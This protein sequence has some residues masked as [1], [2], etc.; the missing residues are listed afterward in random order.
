MNR[1]L[2][3]LL[4]VMTATS[5]GTD[6]TASHAEKRDE[7][8]YPSHG[9]APS[10][11]PPRKNG[12]GTRVVTLG[13]GT[14]VLDPTRAG[15]ATAVG[16]RAYLVDFGRG[17]VDRAEAAFR[18]GFGSLDVR[19]IHH[20]FATHLHSD[21]TV[22]LADLMMTPIA[23]GR[24]APLQIFGPPG[25]A[26]MVE[27]INGAYSEDLRVRAEGRPIGTLPGYQ[28]V[29]REIKEG[30]V[31]RDE[32]VTVKAIRVTHGT[33]K[34]AFAYRFDTVDRTVVISGDTAPTP[35]IVNACN[36]CDL[37]VH[38]VYCEAGFSR[39]PPSF[40]EYHGSAHTSSRQLA[41]IAK[42][43]RPG[44]LVLYHQLLFGCTE[45]QLLEEVTAGYTG[46]VAFANDLDVF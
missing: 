21:H 18:Q 44:K 1:A 24:T 16:D 27:H 7:P 43:A 39:G 38:E 37:L 46:D 29:A 11:T 41:E 19:R 40:R 31:F 25:M 2:V 14:P 34:N 3:M 36:G 10:G 30:V 33:W 22:G 12:I 20:A 9:A 15:P 8:A 28:V 4:S 26:A 5:C 32:N 13:T 17:V 23:L 35:A 6:D 45:A 42:Q